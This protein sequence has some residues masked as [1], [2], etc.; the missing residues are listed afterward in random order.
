MKKSRQKESGNALV[1]VLIVIALFGALSFTLGRQTDTSEAGSISREKAELLAT[2]MISYASQARQV[3]EQMSFTGT[4]MDDY[5]FTLP[6]DAAFN[7]AP[8]LDK[9]YHPDGGGLVPG[10]IPDAAISQSGTDPV[11]GWYM[12]Q[13]NNVD[14]T[15][16]NG[17]DIILVAYQIKREVCE[18]INRIITGTTTIPVLTDSIK[19]VMIADSLFSFGT[20]LDLTT[21]TPGSICPACNEQA[22]LCVQNQVLD[23]YGFYTVVGQR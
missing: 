16:S 10:R 18:Q 12:S 7:T 6:S 5:D 15:D 23:A 21:D 3:V 4:T 14:W 13:F 20:N 22:A 1:Y 11:P 2:Q 17:T 19:E 8:N 9:V